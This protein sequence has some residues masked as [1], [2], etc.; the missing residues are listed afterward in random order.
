MPH[1]E[2]RRVATFIGVVLLLAGLAFAADQ[3]AGVQGVR[4]PKANLAAIEKKLDAVLATQTMILQKL[5][6]MA[7]ELRTIKVRA[8]R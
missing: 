8:T 7:E 3:Q 1:I 2:A 6:A 4:E 5:D